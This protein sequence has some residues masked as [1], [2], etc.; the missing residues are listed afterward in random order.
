[1]L[2]ISETENW[3]GI[4]GEVRVGIREVN[5]NMEQAGTELCKAQVQLG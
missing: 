5:I 3:H 2:Y 4:T 1:M